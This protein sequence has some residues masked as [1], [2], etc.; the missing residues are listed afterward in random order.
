MKLRSGIGVAD[1][2]NGIELQLD[3]ASSLLKLAR[4]QIKCM[5]VDER[6]SYQ[7]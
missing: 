4:R 1:N 2:T 5:S 7:G 6:L 3:M